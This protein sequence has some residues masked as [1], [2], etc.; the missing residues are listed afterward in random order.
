MGTQQTARVADLA[1]RAHAALA[2]EQFS[3]AEELL[4]RLLVVAPDQPGYPAQLAAL[5]QRRGQIGLAIA[6][7]QRAAAVDPDDPHLARL[8]GSTLE[9]GGEPELAREAYLAAVAVGTN[10]RHPQAWIALA[11]LERVQGRLETAEQYAR[12]AVEVAPHRADVYTEL[13]RVLLQSG[14][15]GQARAALT[16]GLR[17]TPSDPD[18]LALR[19]EAVPAADAAT[20]GHDSEEGMPQPQTT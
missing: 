15:Q 16:I 19:D 2:R 6:F 4:L 9:A 8:L 20:R 13:A 1:R 12:R 11:R 3:L 18:L 14:Q 10:P 17:L 7:A 5:Y